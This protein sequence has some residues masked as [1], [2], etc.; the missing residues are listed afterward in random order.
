MISLH[1]SMYQCILTI[2]RLMTE[3]IVKILVP[4]HTNA[5]KRY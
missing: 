4:T 1:Q 2:K 5:L 3:Q